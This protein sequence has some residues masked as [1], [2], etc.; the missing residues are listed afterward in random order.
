[1]FGVLLKREH[2]LEIESLIIRSLNELD[3]ELVTQNLSE[4][5]KRELLNKKN[6]LN[7]IYIRLPL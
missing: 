5:L 4:G 3:N 7:E 6:V 1:M 2:V